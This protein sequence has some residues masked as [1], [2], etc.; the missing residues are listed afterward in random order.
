MSEIF[1]NKPFVSKLG[2]SDL[3]SAERTAAMDLI[4]SIDELRNK[5][6]QEAEPISLETLIRTV[7]ETVIE[8]SNRG[9]FVLESKTPTQ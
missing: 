8:T 2:W 4:R 9:E 3:D 6:E 5:A 1:V 7:R